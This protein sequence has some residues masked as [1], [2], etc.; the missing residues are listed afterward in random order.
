MLGRRRAK[1]RHR[2]PGLQLSGIDGWEWDEARS[3]GGDDP[4]ATETLHLVR[5]KMKNMRSEMKFRFFAH[6]GRHFGRFETEEKLQSLRFQTSKL[7]I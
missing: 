7:E 5:R 6:L 1:A 3:D 4:M 2:L